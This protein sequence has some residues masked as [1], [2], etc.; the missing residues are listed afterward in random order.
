MTPATLGAIL[1]AS[2]TI[3]VVG[4]SP[5]P[6]R[7]SHGVALYLQEA[8]YRIVPVRP[9]VARGRKPL[10]AAGRYAL[11]DT[12]DGYRGRVTVLETATGRT[13]KEFD[14]VSAASMGLLG[15]A[16]PAAAGV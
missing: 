5:N 2:R 9:G 11:L 7:P 6:A 3:A 16:A 8:G 13:V 1:R 15:G 12:G 10:R 14:G 4:L